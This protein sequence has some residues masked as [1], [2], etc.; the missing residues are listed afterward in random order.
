MISKKPKKIWRE[1]FSIRNC[2]FHM[3]EPA[4]HDMANLQPPIF[5]GF[6]PE[7]IWVQKG[8]DNM[9]SYFPVA[10]L[11]RFINHIFQTILSKPA[12]VNCIHRAALCNIKKYFQYA[13]SLEK[14]DWP[15]LTTVELIKKYDTLMYWQMVPHGQS[16]N[17]FI[18]SYSRQNMLK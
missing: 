12:E 7:F 4:W 13:K 14:I 8:D 5:S 15:K 3:G 17:D 1:N 18:V 9:G 11:E 6:L 10:D 16:D 2:A